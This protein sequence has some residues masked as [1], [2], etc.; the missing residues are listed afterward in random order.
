MPALPTLPYMTM[1]ANNNVTSTIKS[2]PARTPDV[3]Q[4]LAS[5]SGSLSKRNDGN[6]WRQRH[7]YVV[8][9]SFL[10]YFETPSSPQ[11][12]GVID[13]ECYTEVERR[14]GNIIILKGDSQLNP[15]LRAMYFQADT[16]KDFEDWTEALLR[17][18]H[19]DLEEE[20]AALSE[21]QTN[22]AQQLKACSAIV[23]DSIAN[24]KKAEDQLYAVR[25]ATESMKGDALAKLREVFDFASVGTSDN[26]NNL[27]LV[28]SEVIYQHKLQS[29]KVGLISR[30]LFE[31]ELALSELKAAFEEKSE[32][33]KLEHAE[34]LRLAQAETERERDAARSLQEELR[35]AIRD[36]GGLRVEFNIQSGVREK[37]EAKKKELSEQKKVLVAEVLSQ[38]KKG[39]E[40]A[41]MMGRLEQQ[42]RDLKHEREW[43]RNHKQRERERAEEAK[44]SHKRQSSTPWAASRGPVPCGFGCYSYNNSSSNNNNAHA[45]SKSFPEPGASPNARTQSFSDAFPET[46]A[47]PAAAVPQSQVE[48]VLERNWTITPAHTD[49][50]AP[51]RSPIPS[52]FGS[53]KIDMLRS[54]S[55]VY[56]MDPDHEFDS[57]SRSSYSLE[58]DDGV[59]LESEEDFASVET[60]MVDGGGSGAG[61]GAGGGIGGGG[62]RQQNSI[63]DEIR[64][65]YFI[66]PPD[67]KEAVQEPAFGISDD[68]M[69]MVE[70]ERE[71]VAKTAAEGELCGAAVKRKAVVRRGNF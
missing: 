15:N 65:F 26:V 70:T 11:P 63:I 57:I 30:E 40:F 44:M 9:H 56:S 66:A 37:L 34:S 3:L 69:E 50:F 68:G 35:G 2:A 46:Q 27:N 4:R 19:R 6:E 12:S 25:S 1:N 52:G 8:P 36:L 53:C 13:L 49:V 10:Y 29:S 32:A 41:N 71:A 28:V 39:S 61:G 18:R 67:R 23:D 62:A 64:R 16:A 55:E 24:Q 48:L 21:L 45:R 38:R 20:I 22:F 31:K 14:D 43:E 58:E 47:S 7:C 51:L 33:L 17:H 5:H 54:L 60:A 59:L 42:V